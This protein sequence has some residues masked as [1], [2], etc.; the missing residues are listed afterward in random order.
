MNIELEVK[1]YCRDLAQVKSRLRK[2]GA[3]HLGQIHQIDTYFKVSKDYYQNGRPKLRIREEKNRRVSF[4]YHL[5]INKFKAQEYET[6]VGDA[7][8]CRLILEKLG[9]KVGTVVDKRRDK[10]R[11]GKINIDLDSV[12]GLGNFIE[13]EI[14]NSKSQKS[15]QAIYEVLKKLGIS[16]SDDISGQSY[17]YLVWKSQNQ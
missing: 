15:L 11:L 12:K 4:E 17:L 14:M 13:V 1:S 5:P 6:D 3:K 8:T 10:Y 2:L 7:K 16:R 9:Y